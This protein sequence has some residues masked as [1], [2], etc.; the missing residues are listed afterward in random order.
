M[1]VQE[2]IDK[3]KEYD[4]LDE[5]VEEVV[6]YLRLPKVLL[7]KG[8]CAMCSTRKTPDCPFPHTCFLYCPKCENFK[9]KKT[10]NI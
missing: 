4:L 3:T 6:Q 1:T 8:V 2:L 7:A 10:N 9:P 5:E